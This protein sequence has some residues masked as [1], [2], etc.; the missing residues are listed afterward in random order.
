MTTFFDGARHIGDADFDDEDIA[1]DG[2]IIT[3]LE[4][5][6]PERV[7]GVDVPANGFPILMLKS[8]A[9][10]STAPPPAD[11]A[12]EGHIAS[13]ASETVTVE[14]PA[15]VSVSFS[16]RDLAKLNTLKRQRVTGQAAKRDMAPNVGGGV[17]RDK[18]KDSDFVFPDE[19]VFPVV[20]PQDV[21][22]AA[23]SWGRYE[24]KHSFE[25]FKKRLTALA[26]R[27]GDSFAARLPEKWKDDSTTKT[28]DEPE[29]TKTEQPGGETATAQPEVAKGAKDC[30]KCGKNFH[31]D[32]PSKYCDNC[33]AKLPA[34]AE[35]AVEADIVKDGEDPAVEATKAKDAKPGLAEHPEP[36][37]DEDGPDVDDDGDG[38]KPTASEAK[39]KKSAAAALLLVHD[40]TCAAFHDTDV[41]A[42]HPVLAKGIPAGVDPAAFGALVTEALTADAGTGARA[43]ELPALSD[44]YG[45]AVALKAADPELLEQAMAD[46]RKAFAEDYPDAHPTPTDIQPGQFKRPYIAAGRAPLSAKAGQK[47]RIPLASHVPDPTDFRRPLIT[48][49]HE[50]ESPASVTK[51]SYYT[52]AARQQATMA[53]T[54][55]HDYIVEQHPNVC[56]MS[57]APVDGEPALPNS[58]GSTLTRA[59][60]AA[61]SMDNNATAVPAAVGTAQTAGAGLAS[62]IKGGEAG[63]AG[64]SPALDTDLVKTVLAG[65][66]TEHLNPITTSL[67]TLAKRVEDLEAAPDPAQAAVRG[68]TTSVAAMKRAPGVETQAGLGNEGSAESM[69]RLVKRAKHPDST[70]SLPA[71]EQ[72]MKLAGSDGVAELLGG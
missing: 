33:G 28:T 62:V 10:P 71:I 5:F 70:V 30:P 64:E 16:P 12:Q 65:L 59:V 42:V 44:A 53:L 61:S 68:G 7:D 23:T 52:N 41:L 47:P 72:L 22:D 37:G 50:A 9:G 54:S 11:T 38:A 39:A 46:I 31:S 48:D 35:K 56:P 26:N 58:M 60:G 69:V 4:K 57:G 32:T 36:D 49:G 34:A 6:G 63:D 18:L 66:L 14:L 8:L 15:D 67:D 3:E 27:K 24:G 55:M 20:T 1:E 2:E 25:E 17:D 29:V 19:R 40:A 51:R 21:H 13:A 43:H 45:L